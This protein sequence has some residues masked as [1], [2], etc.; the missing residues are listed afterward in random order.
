MENSKKRKIIKIVISSIVAAIVLAYV[1]LIIVV[2]STAYTYNL[3]DAKDVETYTISSTDFNKTVDKFVNKSTDKITMSFVNDKTKKSTNLTLKPVGHKTKYFVTYN[4]NDNV[5][6]T[7]RK[8]TVVSRFSK[9][10]FISA[11]TFSKNL[12]GELYIVTGSQDDIVNINLK[13]K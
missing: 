8:G 1:I 11:I 4:S 5:T 6:Y 2:H 13:F 10:K 3:K 12:K 7:V 9:N